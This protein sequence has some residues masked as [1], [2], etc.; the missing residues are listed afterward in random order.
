MTL[1]VYCLLWKWVFQ[2]QQLRVVF[3]KKQQLVLLLS[4]GM[5]VLLSFLLT[6]KLSMIYI[7]FQIPVCIETFVTNFKHFIFSVIK[8]YFWLLH[9]TVH[10]FFSCW[11]KVWELKKCFKRLFHLSREIVWKFIQSQRMSEQFHTWKQKRT[12]FKLHFFMYAKSQ[13]EQKI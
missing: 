11:I 8:V 4:N 10:T 1:N 9:C 6:H 13:T 12:E 3:A 5:H 7:I 2:T